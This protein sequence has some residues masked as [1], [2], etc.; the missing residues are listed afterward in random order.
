MPW[1]TSFGAE[2]ASPLGG[3]S[4]Q[5]FQLSSS[6]WHQSLTSVLPPPL[7]CAAVS[8]AVGLEARGPRVLSKW[9]TWLCKEHRTPSSQQSP[10][11]LDRGANDQASLETFM[12]L[13][14][15]FR[16]GIEIYLPPVMGLR[17]LTLLV[18][19]S[20]IPGKNKAQS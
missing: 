9:P 2:S 3:L 5:S 14:L 13:F 1:G 15:P 12:L 18:P 4:R 19:F 7:Q 20:V 8:G 16:I 11:G 17:C 10:S 6:S